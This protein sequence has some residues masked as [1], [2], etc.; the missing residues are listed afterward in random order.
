[1]F[2]SLPEKMEI[3]IPKE[4]QGKRLDVALAQLLGTSRE[5]SQKLIKEGVVL[6]NGRA[7]KP[8]FLLKGGELLRIP[9]FPKESVSLEPE[10]IP[11]EVIYEDEFLAVINKP[12]GLVVHPGAGRKSHTLVNALLARFSISFPPGEIRPGIVHR[13]DKDTS[14]LIL[15]AKDERTLLE[16]SR[17]FKERSVNKI[18]LALSHG[19]IHEREGRIE[20]PIGRDTRDRKKLVPK[21]QGKF[22]VTEF[23]VLKRYADYT[24]LKLKPYTGRTHQIRVHLSFIG[25]PI[26]GDPLYAQAN[27]WGRK[28]QLLHA[29]ALEFSHPD[30]GKR[31]Y[32]EAPLPLYFQQILDELD[33]LTMVSR[34]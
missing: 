23:E 6:L 18:Y 5:K 20:V 25:H 1:M 26:V 21:A 7:A 13:L 15:I 33:K 17:Q 32:F 19:V 31:L 27:P 22:A 30:S 10:N 29:F 12:A 3:V 2:A 9:S 8:S 34:S 24:F 11:L 4:F 16:L 28:G 14:G